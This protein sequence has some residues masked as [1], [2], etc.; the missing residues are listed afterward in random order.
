[1]IEIEILKIN[2][3]NCNFLGGERNEGEKKEWSVEDKP[4]RHYRHILN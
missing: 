3:V 2:K 4:P 1:M